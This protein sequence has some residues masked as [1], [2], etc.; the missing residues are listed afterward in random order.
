MMI[1][2]MMINVFHATEISTLA[3][4]NTERC[5]YYIFS[6][7][8]LLGIYS[9]IM[10]NMIQS[11]LHGDIA[12]KHLVFN[13]GPCRSMKRYTYSADNSVYSACYI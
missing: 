2:H 5:T 13:L 11:F 3:L 9:C 10:W 4:H 7:Y 1:S 6:M 12:F 8:V